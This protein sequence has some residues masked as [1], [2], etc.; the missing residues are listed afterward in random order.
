MSYRKNFVGSQKRVQISQGKRA[1]VVRAIEVLLY[2]PYAYAQTSA[3]STDP[4][5]TPRNPAF[6]QGLR[7]LT[8][9]GYLGK[10]FAYFS[11]NK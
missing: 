9:A 5:Q 11:N 4:E 6:D 3:N 10:R 2:L 7:F 1:I 8:A